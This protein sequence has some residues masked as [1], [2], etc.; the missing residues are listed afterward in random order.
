MILATASVH[1][2]LVRQSLRTFTSLNVRS[3]DVLDVHGMAVDDWR[4]RDV[5]QSIPRAGGHCHRLKRGLFGALEF[6]GCG[7]ALSQALDRASENYV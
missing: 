4:W 5:G 7:R 6:W 2:H 3:S 1:I